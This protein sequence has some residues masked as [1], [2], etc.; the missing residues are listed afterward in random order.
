MAFFL[1]G[2]ASVATLSG[3]AGVL[4]VVVVGLSLLPWIGRKMGPVGRVAILPLG[5]IVVI[6]S[7][8]LLVQSLPQISA[9][10]G[11]SA[12]LTGRTD[13]WA[14]VLNVWSERPFTGYGWGGVWRGQIGDWVRAIFG[15]DTALSAHNGYLDVL[16]QLGIVGA[17]IV[18]LLL[19]GSIIRSCRLAFSDLQ[20]VWLPL[21][22]GAV[23][24]N[25]FS[26][27]QLT[28]PIGIF[29]I[30]LV[31]AI[32]RVEIRA[33][34]KAPLVKMAAVRGST[35]MPRTRMTRARPR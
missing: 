12:T 13:I 28:R 17:S 30:A 1:A 9:S 4:T 29:L 11:R 26:E 19:L 8:I 3:S 20:Y 6:T 25:S 32:S 24:V 15:F 33:R 18:A 5:I 21:V 2:T 35:A 16:L 34:R 7:G 31:A 10:V 27:S 14:I 22:L 23:L